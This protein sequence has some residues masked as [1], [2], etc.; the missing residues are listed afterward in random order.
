[1]QTR[2][3]KLM[4]QGYVKDPQTFMSILVTIAKKPNQLMI[5]FIR[6]LFTSLA[7]SV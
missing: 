4:L 5:T 3:L 6:V 2:T 1:M 7:M